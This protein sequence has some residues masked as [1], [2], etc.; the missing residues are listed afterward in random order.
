M[1]VLFVLFTCLDM[2]FFVIGIRILFIFLRLQA[3]LA[4]TPSSLRILICAVTSMGKNGQLSRMASEGQVTLRLWFECEVLLVSCV[5]TLG[6]RLLVLHWESMVPGYRWA[7]E[8]GL[9]KSHIYIWLGIPLSASSSAKVW[10]PLPYW[11]CHCLFHGVPI[12]L[13]SLVLIINS[14]QPRVIWEGNHNWGIT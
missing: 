4:R 1:L 6:P 10:G 13:L 2:S 11:Y 3:F 8:C 7:L 5:W 9:F 14:I 12:P